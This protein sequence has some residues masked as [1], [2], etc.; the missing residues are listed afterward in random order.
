[1]ADGETFCVIG[2][3]GT[4]KSVT[5]KLLL[6]LIPFDGGEIYFRGRPISAMTEDELNIMRSEIGM[7]F[8]AGALFDSMTVFENVAYPLE[9]KGGY[10][11]ADIKR[12]VR[13]KLALVGLRDVN[14]LFPADLS[15]GMV[16]RVGLAR[17]IATDPNIILY[18]EPT[19]GLDPTNVNRI[20]DMIIDLKRRLKIASVVVT[21][22]MQSVF[23]IA[24]TV[25]LLYR[26]KI[27]FIGT[28]EELR[29]SRDPMVT[30]FIE[31]RIGD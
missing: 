13:A 17:A 18:D 25:A 7:L 1:V 10:S 15:G 12:I 23:R 14:D 16:K 30:Q 28:I 2:G 22:H 27:A 24:D 5:L 3:S 11:E 8:Q 9:E 21:H 6:G 29:S 20:D 4:G 31:G 26:K 19:A